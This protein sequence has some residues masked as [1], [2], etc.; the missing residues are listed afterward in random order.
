MILCTCQV[1]SE[2]NFECQ[3]KC[4]LA[5]LRDARVI[6]LRALK[7]T[8]IMLM[9]LSQKINPWGSLWSCLGVFGAGLQP[10]GPGCRKN[11]KTTQFYMLS[12]FCFNNF[13][14]KSGPG[15][16]LALG[17]ILAVYCPGLGPDVPGGPEFFQKPT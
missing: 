13:P 5:S 1:R 8:T 7:Q 6:A 17:L 11:L 9:Q 2:Y 10:D 4:R 16:V 15:G 3:N 14:K 12:N